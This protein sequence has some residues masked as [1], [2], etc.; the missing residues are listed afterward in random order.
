M[1]NIF[2]LILVLLFIGCGNN[3]N[4]DPSVAGTITDPPTVV[5]AD[6]TEFIEES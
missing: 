1:K 2:T 6:T 5:P 3:K 4:V